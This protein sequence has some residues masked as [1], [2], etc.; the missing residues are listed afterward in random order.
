MGITK[1]IKK[2]CVQTAVYWGNSQPDGYGGTTFDTA[3]EIKCRWEDKLRVVADKNGKEYHQR[4]ELL[5]TQDVDVE[6]WL[7][8]G[9]LNDFDSDVDITN[10]VG[11]QGAYQIMG[12]DKSPLIRS[13]TEFVR[14]VFLG[15][16]NL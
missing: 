16:G 15:F 11:I 4:A 3:V 14:T 2:V 12:V 10:P 6:G 7:Y 1:F 8:L 13:T 9:T 5:V